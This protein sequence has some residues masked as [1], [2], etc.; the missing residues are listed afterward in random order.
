MRNQREISRYNK[1]I[2]NRKKTEKS[3]AILGTAMISCTALLPLTPTIQ[4]EATNTANVDPSAFIRE[5]GSYAS[6]IAAANDLYASVMMAQAI[7]ESG[8]GTSALASAPNYNLFGIKG[9]YNGQS[10]AMPTGEYLNGQWVTITDSFR[11]YPSYA[12]SFADN[13]YLLKNQSF[14]GGTYYYSG[15]WKSNTSSYRDA[16]AWLTGR[17][18]TDPNYSTKL[19]NIITTYNLTQY[20]TGGAGGGIGGGISSGGSTSATPSANGQT[21]TVQSGDTL[22]RIALNHNV[23]VSDLKAWNGLSSDR[24]QAGQQL[25]I[26]QGGGESAPTN[27]TTAPSNGATYTVQS[28]DT[29]YRIALNNNVS[30]DE[31]KGWNGLA[32]D[33]IQVGQQLV[34]S[35]NGGGAAAPAEST[36]NGGAGGT[37]TVQSGDTLYRIALNN[38]VSLAN[39]KSWNNLTSDTIYVGQQLNVGS[40][41]ATPPASSAPAN[42]PGG[43]YTVQ[44]GDN[45]Y[46]IALKNGVSVAD[47]KGWNGLTSDNISIG[48]QLALSG[49]SAGAPA[50]VAPAAPSTPAPSN[51]AKYVV[52]SGD[53]LYRIA[54][55]HNI[56]VDQLKAW[57][58]ISD[59]SVYVGQELTVSGNGGGTSVNGEEKYKVKSGD[60]LYSIAKK[61]D[62]TVDK[63]KELNNLTSDDIQIDQELKVKE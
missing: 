63:L 40:G 51:G 31:I 26:G 37:Y 17:Y 16:T 44:A 2:D 33:G 7:V 14:G 39:L 49:S 23:T 53:N 55:N 35:A 11:K 22:Y 58:N 19:N 54:L 48:Q 46:R 5:I 24:I 29:L 41:A 28:G 57:N 27:T 59:D 3:M 32:G 21:Y 6:G 20:D 52:Q 36:N 15:A 18:A 45:L 42:N 8:W 1:R 13:A 34:V 43:V 9:N 47:L 56:S 61:H 62:L 38:Q 25:V 50:P 12:E 4:A 10:V 30:V 60:T